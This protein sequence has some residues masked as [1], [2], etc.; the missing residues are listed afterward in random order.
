[1]KKNKFI[2]GVMLAS[3]ML[4]ASCSDYDDWNTA[5]SSGSSESTQ[6]LWANISANENLSQFA[7]LLKKAGYD[8]ELQN[9]RFYTVWAPLNG[10]YDYES[11]ASQM[12]STNLVKKFVMNHIANYNHTLKSNMDDERVHTLNEK[13]YVFSA[14]NGGLFDELQIAQANMPSINGVMHTINGY[15]QFYPNS[16][17]YLSEVE[18]ADSI[19]K[20]ILRYETRTL[21]T[22]NSIAGPVDSLG[23]QTY[24]DSVIVVSNSFIQRINADLENE[25]S[26]YVVF[27]PTDEAYVKAYNRIL[28]YYNYPESF[29]NIPIMDENGNSVKTSASVDPTLADSLVR[30]RIASN[31]VYSTNDGYNQWLDGK[32]RLYLDT[33]R[34]T[35]YNK[36]SDGEELL[37]H[38]VGSPVKMS[39]GEVRLVDSLTYKPWEVWSDD[40]T[41]PVT[42]S[43]YRAYTEAGAC[44][45][46]NLV[47]DDGDVIVKYVDVIPTNTSSSRPTVYF[48]LPS[49][50]ST[51]YNVYMVVVPPSMVANATDTLP[52][53]FQVQINYPK[54]GSSV[55]TEDFGENFKTNV[56]GDIDSMY[57]GQIT[58]PLSVAGVSDIYPQ[59]V[60]SV[61]RR[62]SERKTLGN[63]MRIAS[64]VLR[65]VEY[66]NYQPFVTNKED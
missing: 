31:L 14:Q 50:R 32:D 15:A 19:S 40:I 48:N 55:A 10:T 23:R 20:Y 24:S 56:D 25:D 63:R 22:E 54:T 6:S 46:T 66:D 27:L 13:S 8:K 36:L 1:M 16:Y 3:T 17:E 52:V 62:T 28:P 35:R 53:R 34:S 11:L 33:L 47:G 38:T 12:D 42:T 41:I 26:S 21:D 58:F 2:Y 60:V 59:M 51:A 65:P 64:I 37:S 49:V 39:N 57:I 43:S 30:Y 29:T 61:K 4:A 18:G 45:V 9:N 44:E 5:Y 7:E